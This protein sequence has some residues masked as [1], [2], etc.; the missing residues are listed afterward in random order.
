MKQVKKLS[1][2]RPNSQIDPMPFLFQ[3]RLKLAIR[4]ILSTVDMS[5]GEMS[6]HQLEG[7]FDFRWRRG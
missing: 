6:R 4:S 2:F 7:S 1:H 5:V 3:K